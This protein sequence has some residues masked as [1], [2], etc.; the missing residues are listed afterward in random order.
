MVRRSSGDLGS[1]TQIFRQIRRVVDSQKNDIAVEVLKGYEGRMKQ[2]VFNNGLASDNQSIS[3]KGYSTKSMLVG[4]SSFITKS[5]ANKVFGSKKKRRNL[6]WVTVK[7]NA[8]AVI[9]GGYKE[10]RKLNGRPNDK[11]DLEFTSDLRNGIQVG[12][13]SKGPALGY[14]NED[15]AIKGKGNESRYKRQYLRRLCLRI[16]P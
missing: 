3:P 1:V 7:G 11:V 4:S 16:K 14:I 12:S 9:E 8:L 2:R 6:K 5:G 10:F 15:S 13:T